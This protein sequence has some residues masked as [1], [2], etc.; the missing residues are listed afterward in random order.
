MCLPLDSAHAPCA[1][2]LQ[3][4][5]STHALSMHWTLQC[6][7][8][9]E[10]G[11]RERSSA[12][13]IMRP[14][15]VIPLL[16]HFQGAQPSPSVHSPSAAH[17]MASMTATRASLIAAVCRGCTY[18]PDAA[19]PRIPQGSPMLHPTP[20]HNNTNTY[21]HTS[22]SHSHS[23]SQCNPVAATSANVVHPTPDP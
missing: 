23:R 20:P 8:G 12:F 13:P 17:I 11:C 21:H 6:L 9:L 2:D 7:A 22:H 14:P 3:G 10:G 15:P 5:V 1:K 4:T 18:R 16:S 19:P